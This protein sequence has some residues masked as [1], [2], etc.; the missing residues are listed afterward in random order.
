MKKTY[1]A[2]GWMKATEEDNFKEGCLPETARQHAGRD[3]FEAD[4]IKGCIEKICS[5][6]GVDASTSDYLE[7]NACDELGRLDVA[8]M[9]NSNSTEATKAERKD[10]KKGNA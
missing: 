8:I 5:F 3:V 4:T 10:W 2:D 6:L 7:R 9:E 1:R